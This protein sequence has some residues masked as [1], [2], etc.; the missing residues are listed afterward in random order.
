MTSTTSIAVDEQ[1]QRQHR[2]RSIGVLVGAMVG[3]MLGAPLEGERVAALFHLSADRTC[4]AARG[5]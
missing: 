5:A 2:H 4:G 1:Q 3:D